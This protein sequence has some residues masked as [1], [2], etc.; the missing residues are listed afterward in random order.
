MGAG[1]QLITSPAH[2]GGKREFM[3]L[4]VQL[5]NAVEFKGRVSLRLEAAEDLDRRECR[6]RELPAFQD[7]LV[8]FT[9]AVG[10]VAL[11]T[12]DVHHHQATGLAGCGVKANGTALQLEG[13][14]HRVKHA[15]Q[16]EYNLRL[17]RVKLQHRVLR[18]QTGMQSEKKEQRSPGE[19]TW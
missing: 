9:V 5:E 11:A 4:S 1:I 6:F 17:R 15:G 7:I 14:L 10:P 13:P 3:F 8:H 18:V 19:S 2:R 12:G 16:G